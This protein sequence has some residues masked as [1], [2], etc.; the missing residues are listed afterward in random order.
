MA[1]KTTRKKKENRTRLGVQ[2]NVFTVT[3]TN[4]VM[5]KYK[6]QFFKRIH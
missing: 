4:K 3:A 1:I 6:K 5:H 2:I